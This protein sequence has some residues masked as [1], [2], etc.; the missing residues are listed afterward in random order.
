MIEKDATKFQLTYFPIPADILE[1]KNALLSISD[2][3]ENNT[4]KIQIALVSIFNGHMVMLDGEMFG[5]RNY[6]AFIKKAQQLCDCNESKIE[7][8]KKRLM[9][10]FAKCE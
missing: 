1:A 8:C 9:D 10:W 4:K 5:L 2:N 6:E 3:S 7:D